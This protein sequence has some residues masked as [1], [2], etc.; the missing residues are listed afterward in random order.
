M[1]SV[2]TDIGMHH[3]LPPLVHKSKQTGFSSPQTVG[4]VLD[5]RQRVVLASIQFVLYK[6]WS[7]LTVRVHMCVCALFMCDSKPVSCELICLSV[8]EATG[9]RNNRVCGC[10]YWMVSTEKIIPN[11]P[12]LFLSKHSMLALSEKVP[13]AVDWYT[14][15]HLS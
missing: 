9:T 12:S 6:P 3:N 4:C 11:I 15:C 13:R 8:F 5:L 10:A 1:V 7:S 2:T 14:F